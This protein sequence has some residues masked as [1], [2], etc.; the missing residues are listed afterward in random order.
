MG[1]LF[2][3]REALDHDQW[4]S[5]FFLWQDGGINHASYDFAANEAVVS[6]VNIIE[7][8]TYM[9]PWPHNFHMYS[10]IK[11]H[12]NFSSFYPSAS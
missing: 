10:V 2:L 12:S 4:N 11:P 1:K 3:M 9:L 6:P 8:M 7:Q 5:D